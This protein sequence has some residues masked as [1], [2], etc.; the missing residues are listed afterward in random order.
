MT[1]PWL[2]PSPTWLEVWVGG[3]RLQPPETLTEPIADGFHLV[4]L[5]YRDA[6]LDPDRPAFTP[7]PKD[8]DVADFGSARRVYT[9][10]RYQMTLVWYWPVPRHAR[11]LGPQRFILQPRPDQP[12]DLRIIAWRAGARDQVVTPYDG[13]AIVYDLDET[14]NGDAYTVLMSPMLLATE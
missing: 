6:V 12:R 14:E 2:N 11:V 9:S 10:Q 8:L 7:A 3:P 4:G 13:V 1:A 5:V